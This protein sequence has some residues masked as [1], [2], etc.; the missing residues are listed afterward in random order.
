MAFNPSHVFSAPGTLYAAPLGTTEPTSVSGAWPAGWVPLGYTDQ[1]S[2]I[3]ITPTWQAVTVEEEVMAISN[4]MTDVKVNWTFALS[5]TTQ[6]NLLFALNG[7]IGTGQVSGSS[8]VNPDGSIWTEMPA[9]GSEA[10]VMLGWDALPEGATSGQFGIFR[11]VNR[12]AIQTGGIKQIHRKGSTKAMY[13]VVFTLEK[14]QGV[15]P[16]RAIQPASYAS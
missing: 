10:R 14:P 9:F 13:A 12:K 1:G 3:D 15:Q 4:S 11:W 7:G 6:Q 8:G 16:F 2:E 5:E